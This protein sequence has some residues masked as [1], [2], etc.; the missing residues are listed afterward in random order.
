MWFFTADEHYYHKNII[1]YT[2]RP[3]K[4][5]KDMHEVLINN[6]NDIVGDKDTTV[7][8]GDFA[9]G[10]IG[11]VRKVIKR[12]NGKHIFLKGSHDKAIH[13]LGNQDIIDYRGRRLEFTLNNKF[14]VID[15]YC[16]RTWARSHYNTWHLYGH[17]HGRLDPIGKS[18]DVGVDNNNFYPV[19]FDQITEIMKERPDNP[20]YIPE[21][22]RRR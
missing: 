5:I 18:W 8:A 7:H 10:S 16:L 20:N 11:K 9:F 17:S 1:E 19:S 22:L 2:G 12:L 15:H 4:G 13:R 3:F 14:I 6:H 21:E